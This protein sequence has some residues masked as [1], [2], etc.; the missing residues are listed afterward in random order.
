M[1]ATTK[2]ARRRP[3]ADRTPPLSAA[4]IVIASAGGPTEWPALLAAWFGIGIGYSLTLTPSGKVGVNAADAD[5]SRKMS[6]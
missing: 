4:A 5:W 6:R 3:L 1:H 2:T